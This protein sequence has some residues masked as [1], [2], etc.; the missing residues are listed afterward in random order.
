MYARLLSTLLSCSFLVAQSPAGEKKAEP[1]AKDKEA[2]LAELVQLQKQIISQLQKQLELENALRAKILEEIKLLRDNINDREALFKKL[3]ADLMRY[4]IEAVNWKVLA[5]TRQKQ[6]ELLLEQIRE[7]ITAKAGID[8]K[9]PAGPEPLKPNPPPVK[10]KGVIDEVERTGNAVLVKVSLGTE[11]GV[12]KYHT[13]EVYRLQPKAEY[14]GMI[15]I[16]EA[17]ARYAIGRQVLFGN[18]AAPS[19]LKQGDLVAD[20]ITK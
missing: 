1:P 16:V 12:S 3:D 17:H 8:A 19:Q 9:S 20:T 4:R 14:L 7:L 5:E 18:S 2:Q 15:R 10:V 11:H 13:L 6:N